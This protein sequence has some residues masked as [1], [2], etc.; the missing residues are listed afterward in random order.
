MDV[1]AQCRTAILKDLT[2]GLIRREAAITQSAGG[3]LQALQLLAEGGSGKRDDARDGSGAAVDAWVGAVLAL[4]A[5]KNVRCRALHL[6]L[7]EWRCARCPHS[8]RAHSS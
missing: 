5:G 8:Y 1:S 6:A 7:R 4:L 2:S 3:Q